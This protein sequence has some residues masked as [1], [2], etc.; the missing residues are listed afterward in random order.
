MK[1]RSF[2]VASGSTLL[3]SSVSE[4]SHQPSVALEF[5]LAQVP[6]ESPKELESIVV[7]FS[8]LSI[9]PKYLNEDKNM[10]VKATLS[11]ENGYNTVS[12]TTIKPRNGVKTDLTQNIGSLTI[13]GIESSTSILS[14]T[15]SVEIEQGDFSETYTNSFNIS[16]ST[17]PQSTGGSSS[18]IVV[19][20]TEYKRHVF[21]SDGTF[22]LEDSGIVDVLVVAGG[23]GGAAGGGG[24]GGLVYNSNVSL[25]SGSYDII[26]GSGGSK[27]ARPYNSGKGENGEDSYFDRNGIEELRAIGGG[28]GGDQRGGGKDGGSGGGTG[29][30]AGVEGGSALQPGTNPAA[31]IDAGNKGGFA[32][33]TTNPNSTAGGGGAG[34]EGQ[35][36][37][38]FDKPGDGGDG[39]DLS[40]RLGSDIGA[41]GAFAGGAAGGG[42]NC[43]DNG[44]P[45]YYADGGVGGG[46]D[47]GGDCGSAP[48]PDSPVNNTGSGGRHG[49]QNRFKPTS[50]ADGIV[51]VR[52][53]PK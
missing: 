30:N 28:G 14:A 36:A 32:P 9:K 26:V 51:V 44:S 47:G 34:Q 6:D 37:D 1:R 24:A 50:G 45:Q 41:N 43:L 35:D 29:T 39:V 2:V 27:G 25:S 19:G 42:T 13:D 49:T 22:R 21:T 5:E 12:K 31:D 8:N 40:G 38:R 52:I 7:E 48:I 33:D 15:V 46:P 17:F 53:R 3:I 11:I 4:Y 20:D 18:K 10:Q 23:G 16:G